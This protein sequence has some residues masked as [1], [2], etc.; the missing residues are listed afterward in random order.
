MHLIGTI[1]SYKQLTDQK[2]FLCFLEVELAFL[3]FYYL[4][5]YVNTF[6]GYFDN[7]RCYLLSYLYMSVLF[8]FK[9][10]PMYR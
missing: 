7:F 9:C 5:S 1:I 3:V 2:S 10:K 4:S 8:P 6:L